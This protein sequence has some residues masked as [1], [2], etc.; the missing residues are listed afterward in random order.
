MRNISN[1]VTAV[2]LG[3]TMALALPAMAGAYTIA[4]DNYAS[5]AGASLTF[6]GGDPSIKNVDGYDSLGVSG[7]VSGEISIGQSITMNFDQAQFV[8]TIDLV[9]LFTDGNYNDVGDEVAQVT[10]VY[11]SD[12]WTYTLTADT[13][14]SAAWTGLGTV[15]SVESEP[16][17]QGNG[18]VW[19]LT[20]PFGGQ[21]VDSIIFA[22]LDNTQAPNL[23]GSNSDYGI[24]SV[25]TSATP[26]PGSVWL[27]GSGLLGLVG[28]RSA[29]R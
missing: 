7:G 27:L 10:G 5:L 17:R 11:G 20:D 12:S 1:T 9:A 22:A 14:S 8:N 16:G 28:L 6:S 4:P 2:I 23:G 21:A 26:V 25:T 19:T 13:A 15:S 3:L 29:R 24:G 18:G